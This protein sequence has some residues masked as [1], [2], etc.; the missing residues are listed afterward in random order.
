MQI[1]MAVN[2]GS[3]GSGVASIVDIIRVA[4]AVREQIDS[5]IPP[6]EMHLAGPSPSVALSTEMTLHTT[7]ELRDLG[8]VRFVR[9]A[10]RLHRREL[11]VGLFSERISSHYPPSPLTEGAPSVPLEFA[12]INALGPT[13]RRALFVNATLGSPPSGS[14][15]ACRAGVF[16]TSGTFGAHISLPS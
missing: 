15:A 1:G 9:L 14:F 16:S 12:K 3:F 10:Y 7:C 6:I 11:L 2:N 13:R 4:D 5:R 8:P